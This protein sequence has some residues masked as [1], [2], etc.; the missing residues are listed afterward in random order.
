MFKFALLFFLI[1]LCSANLQGS[2]IIVKQSTDCMDFDIKLGLPIDSFANMII[3]KTVPSGEEENRY[4]IGN[5]HLIGVKLSIP[6]IQVFY[7]LYL[8]PDD[9]IRIFL[10]G[11]CELE[12]SSN[13]LEDLETVCK[14]FRETIT[15]Y[16][17]KPIYHQ[18]NHQ[19][20]FEKVEEIIQSVSTQLQINDPS[21]SPLQ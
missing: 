17:D 14:V 7:S 21:M 19:L 4:A 18:E 15:H 13:R 9:T 16:L 2:V 11:H 12:M 5:R 1:P 10:N 8:H 3:Y 6:A 20:T